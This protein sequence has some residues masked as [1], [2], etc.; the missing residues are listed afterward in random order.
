M[1]L[2]ALL[3]FIMDNTLHQYQFNAGGSGCYHWCRV[4]MNLLAN[5]GHV[6]QDVDSRMVELAEATRRAQFE[7]PNWSGRF[8][9]QGRTGEYREETY[10]L[11]L[12][13]L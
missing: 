8:W 11:D 12:P 5:A 6:P 4:L 13:G 1:E 2:G 3:R 7:Y 10:S 9:R